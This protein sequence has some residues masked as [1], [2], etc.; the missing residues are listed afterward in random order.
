MNGFLHQLAEEI[1]NKHRDQLGDVLVVLPSNRAALFLRKALSAFI[2]NPVLGPEILS[3]EHFLSRWSGLKTFDKVRLSFELYESYLEVYTSEDGSPPDSIDQFSK[4]GQI[5]LQDFNE[6][7]R[8]LVPSEELYRS[9]VDIKR[10]ELWMPYGDPEPTPLMQKFLNFWDTL[11]PLYQAYRK[12]LSAQ[13]GAYQ[14]MLYR[15]LCDDLDQAQEHWPSSWTGPLYIAG[16]NAINKAEETLFKWLVKERNAQLRWDVDRFYLD[17]PKHEAGMFLRRFQD[18]EAFTED[19]E[20]P[21]T[22]DYWGTTAKKIRVWA[23]AKNMAQAHHAGRLLQDRLKV[24]P[25]LTRTALVLAN[26]DLLL[27][28]LNALPKEVKHVNVTMGYSI[29]HGLVVDFLEQLIRHQ[30]SM[31]KGV[32]AGKGLRLY[33]RNVIRL[34]THPLWKLAFPEDPI[35]EVHRAIVR[36]N[37]MYFKPGRLQSLWEEA[38]GTWSPRVARIFEPWTSGTTSL[39]D[40]AHDLRTALDEIESERIPWER[41]FLFQVYKVLVQLHE[42][43]SRF[44]RLESLMALRTFLRPL[45]QQQELSFYG[46]PLQG[47]QI[48]G[49]LETRTLDFECVIVLSVNEEILPKGS[50]GQSFIPFDLKKHYKLP[51]TA[52]KDA[53][54]AYHFYRLLQRASEVHLV[55]TTQTDDF[56]SGERSRYITQIEHELG[57]TRS[58]IDYKEGVVTTPLNAPELNPWQIEKSPELVERLQELMREGLSPSALNRYLQAPME[59]YF[60]YVLGLREADEVEE[61]LEDSTFG[62]VVHD[63]LEQ[64]Y[65]PLEGQILTP[66]A[67]DELLSK[68]EEQVDQSWTEKYAGGDPNTGQNYLGSRAAKNYVKRFL[69][70]E[71][72]KVKRTEIHLIATE[73]RLETLFTLPDGTEVLIKGTADRIHREN[74]ALCIIDYKSGSVKDKNISWMGWAHVRENDG[75]EKAVQLMLYRWLWHRAEGTEIQD[76][77]AGIYWLRRPDRPNF[78]TFGDKKKALSEED[79]SEFESGLAS[80]ILEILDTDVPFVNP[81]EAPFLHFSKPTEV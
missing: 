81:V 15:H 2:E 77:A 57:R 78:L 53:I 38:E 74:G 8:Y 19:G 3:I 30:E 45:L 31:E 13:G 37:M 42:L 33:H 49:M 11:G 41:E 48:M 62:D 64:L 51:G 73:K 66:E 52:E 6:V 80:V 67:M 61:S 36:R 59:F 76:I 18:I 24:D 7:D 60:Q 35:E 21:W 12:R 43:N 58:A 28:V 4:W 46:E 17:T 70:M 68:H 65:K 9:L 34:L 29:R 56:G 69:T 47:L 63:A 20:L 10:I 1:W 14:G 79:L 39:M 25:D 32:L 5:L 40:W 55:H 23:T 75:L 22:G 26:E 44:G 50:G 71:R 72:E 54:F 16:F 27:P